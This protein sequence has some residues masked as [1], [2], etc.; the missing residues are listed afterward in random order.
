M[1]LREKQEYID[2]FCENTFDKHSDGCEGCPFNYETAWCHVGSAF[3]IKEDE[4]DAV[5]AQMQ[6]KP[7]VALAMEVDKTLNEMVN[8]PNHYNREGA[9]ESIDEMILIFGEEAVA[10]FC[11]CNVWKYRYRASEKNG[12]EDLKKSDWYIRKYKELTG[13]AG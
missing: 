3:D 2:N 6:P 8:H 7:D 9:M 5:L 1:T 12:I 13:N 11:L 4:V 10:N